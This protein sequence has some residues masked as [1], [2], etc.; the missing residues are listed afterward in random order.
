MTL[1]SPET[2]H[3]CQSCWCSSD[4]NQDNPGVWFKRIKGD[5]LKTLPNF[6]NFGMDDLLKDIFNSFTWLLH[7]LGKCFGHFEF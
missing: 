7:Q 3:C 5:V 4:A 2:M 1:K 6:P